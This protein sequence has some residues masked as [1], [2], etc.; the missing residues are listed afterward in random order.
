MDSHPVGR[1]ALLSIHP[2]YASAILAGRKQV[3]FRK[4]PIHRDVSHVLVYSTAPVK[5][6]VGAFEVAG[7]DTTSPRRLW[8]TYAPVSGI[9]REDFF[10][11][12]AHRLQGTGILVGKVLVPHTPLG[13]RDTLGI[14]YPPQSFQYVPEPV[15]QMVLTDMTEPALVGVC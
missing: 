10:R 3:E 1:V 12:Y 8:D 4:R 5:S 7:Q 13:L 14:T 6:I 9:D 11:Y 15:A 2:V